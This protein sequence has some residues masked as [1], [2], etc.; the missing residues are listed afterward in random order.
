MPTD[1][2]T[3]PTTETTVSPA[4]LPADFDIGKWAAEQDSA[5]DGV[6]AAELTDGQAPKGDTPQGSEPGTAAPTNKTGE[7]NATPGAQGEPDKNAKPGEQGKESQYAKA[8]KEAERRDRSWKALE[9]EKAEFRQ[10]EATL[11]TQLDTMKRELQQLQ[12]AR[13]A[14]PARDEHGATAETYDRLAKRYADEGNDEMAQA[15][16]ERADR[17]RRQTPV[18]HQ[19]A[20]QAEQWKTPEFQQEWKRHTEE[21]VAAEPALNDPQNPVLKAANTLLSDKN[22]APYFLAR[23]DGIRAAVEV[24]RLVEKS[25]RIDAIQKE[26]ADA[27]AEN[28]RLTKLTSPRGSHPSAPPNGNKRLEDMSDSEAHDEIRRIAAAADRGEL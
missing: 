12:A 11:R 20:A 7:T 13:S 16:Q 2:A 19:P 14:G 3:A 26:L 17:L 27:K 15:A 8:Q 1:T 25:A 5:N 24:A 22:W 9:Q 18:V 6:P 21:L 23:P 28:Q 10:Q 4:N